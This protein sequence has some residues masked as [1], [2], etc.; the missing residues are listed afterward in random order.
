LSDKKDVTRLRELAKK[1][2]EISEL[3]IQQ[4]NK[5][6]WTAVNDLRMIRP[7]VHTRDYPLFLLEYEDELTP[8]ISDPFLKRIETNLLLRI[9]EWNHLRCDRVIE[10]HIDCP[11]VFTDSGFGISAGYGA[12]AP[13]TGSAKPNSGKQIYEKSVHF[14]PQIFNMDDLEKIK[15]PVVEYNE[16]ATLSR[17]NLLK[18]IF[19]GIM[20]V[21]LLGR[22]NF[23]CTTMDDVMTWTGINEGMCNLAL[24]PELM[25]AIIDRYIE[26]NIVCILQYEKLGLIS[27]NNNFKNIGTNCPG[28]TSAL[29][30][31]TESGI[32]AKLNDIWGAHADQIMTGVSPDMTQ[33]FAFEHE[34]KYARMFPLLSYGCCERLDHKL[35]LLKSSFPNLRKVSCSPFS[36]LESTMEQLGKGYVISW[37][38]NSTYLA[39]SKL[40]MELLRK[41]IIH[42]CELTKKYDVNL[43]LNMKTIITLNDEPQRLWQWCDMAME[44]IRAYFG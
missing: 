13:A 19:D 26:A 3:P 33:E 8:I 29:P 7:V 25:H 14:D 28:Y 12:N 2:R 20:P 32:G 40:E 9:Y 4:Y 15:T 17:L 18:E 11:A 23:N 1:V 16:D 43:V 30:E 42:A 35:D 34:K 24:E 27:S 31:P 37:K 22:D 5:K 36:D 38:P 21:K 10:P 39:G 6:L 41:E 44:L